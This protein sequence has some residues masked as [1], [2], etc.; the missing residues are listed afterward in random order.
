MRNPFWFFFL[1][2]LVSAI[3]IAALG[4]LHLIGVVSGRTY[5]DLGLALGVIFVVSIWY[6]RFRGRG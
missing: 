2:G 3:G 6:A 5:L 4:V 1:T